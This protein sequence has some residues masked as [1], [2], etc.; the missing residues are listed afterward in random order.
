MDK[1]GTPINDEEREFWAIIILHSQVR[2]NFWHNEFNVFMK[3]FTF[4]LLFVCCYHDRWQITKWKLLN[5]FF[6]FHPM[7]TRFNKCFFCVY[8]I[9]GG[10]LTFEFFQWHL[11]DRVYRLPCPVKC[12][13]R[14]WSS[15]PFGG[16]KTILIKLIY[17]FLISFQNK[18]LVLIKITFW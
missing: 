15:M 10:Y 7:T 1:K 14:N 9:L 8:S 16:K 12:L 13:K 18:L 6:M 2:N 3:I 4:F 17:V 11:R 5:G